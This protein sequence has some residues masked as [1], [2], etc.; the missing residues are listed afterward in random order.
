M[1]DIVSHSGY[2]A[3][4]G[5]PNAGK[6]TLLNR[7]VGEKIAAVS[8]K[9]QTTRHEIKGIYTSE[10]G[11]A[12]FIDTPG[13]HKPGHLLNRRMM[14]A[15]NDALLS[16]D[17]VVLMRDASVSTGNGDRFV[18]EMVKR[19][20]KPAILVLN[21]IDKIKKKAEL[22]PLIEL[23]RTEYEF[24]EVIPVSALKDEAVDVL[25]DLIIEHLP[26]GSP[27][28]EGDELTDQSMRTIAAEMVREKIL[29]N[30]GEE[31]PYVTAVVTERWDE[32]D[33]ERPNIYCAIYVERESQK[34]II[35]GK[36]GV[37]LKKIGTEARADIESLLGRQ[38][39]LQL[40][41]KV[42]E[43]WRNSESRL[44]EIGVRSRSGK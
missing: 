26:S 13:V 40:F 18:L 36:G 33:P 41:V 43:D 4:I 27:L 19:S 6:S 5:R 14:A 16:V 15:V 21:K 9:P 24:Q 29:Q 37:K 31:I 25:L 35:I 39:N 38:V 34:G 8:N 10:R 7:I 3:L 1:T 12:V 22:L 30:T 32:T 11:Q 17:L 23:Y 2:V 20:A 28:F 44:D 42:V